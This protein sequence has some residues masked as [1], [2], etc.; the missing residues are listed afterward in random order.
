MRDGRTLAHWWDPGVG[1]WD[2]GTSRRAHEYSSRSLLVVS[3][4]AVALEREQPSDNA[5][6]FRYALPPL[7][8]PRPLPMSVTVVVSYRGRVF[9]VACSP[10]ERLPSLAH[11][12]ASLTGA[13]PA[14]LKL[15]VSGRAVLLE[16]DADAGVESLLAPRAPQPP[17]V[18]ADGGD[19]TA[20]A[21]T[22]RLLLLCTSAA[23]V[24]TVAAAPAA[25]AARAAAAREPPAEHEA[26]VEARRSSAAPPQPA[27]LPAGPHT[28]LSFRVLQRRTELDAAAPSALLSLDAG[29][30]NAAG[31]H[32]D[33][34]RPLTPP[35]AAALAL[36]H[37]LACD[38]GISAVMAARRYS[39]AL[40]SEMPPEGKVGISAVCV[41]GVNGVCC[42]GR[43]AEG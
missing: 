13:E 40:L 35:S 42:A 12:L 30:D 23:D 7:P 8:C 22:P 9:E 28:F 4:R 26:A 3:C 14:T 16:A 21:R 36:L 19:A 11:R 27:R 25:A 34:A 29:G 32:D 39:V 31:P 38:P 5:I 37:R 20:P 6:C 24:A 15:L 18:Q 33:A 1:P 10:G 41:L 43:G 17:S 2:L